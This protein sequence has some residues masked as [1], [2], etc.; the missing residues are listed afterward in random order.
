M[1]KNFTLVLLGLFLILGGVNA[2]NYRK[3]DFT[4]WSA[5]TIANLQADAAASST[6]GWSDIE[7]AADAGDG[8]VA[9]DATRNNC[10]WY[11]SSE[12]GTLKANGVTISELEGLDFGSSY[13]DNR[14]LAIA[15]NYPETSL[16]T[17]AGPAYLW[18][19]GGNK[20]AGS[21]L[22]CFTIP[23]VQIGQK[24]TMVVESHKPSDARGISLFVNDINVETN[25]I[26]ES[27]TPTTQETYTWEN[28]TLPDGVEDEDGDGLVDILVYNTNGCHIYSL[29]VGDSDQKSKIAYLYQGAPDATQAVAE[30]IANYEVE[31]IDITATQKTAEELKGYDAVIIASNVNDATYAAELKNA[32][33]W[34]PIVNTS[35]GLYEL[36]GLGSAVQ[37]SIPFVSIKSEGHS[38]FNGIEIIEEGEI[39]GIA[40][41]G[42]VFGIQNLGDYFAN[43]VIVGAAMDDETLTTIHV[44]NATHNAYIYIPAGNA[45][46][47]AN[48]IKA[49]ANSKGKVTAAPKPVISL[50]YKN[51]NTDVTITSGVPGAQIFYTTDGSEP[52][53]NST[54]YTETF[55]VTTACTVKAVAKGDGYTLSDVAES[56][57]IIKQQAAAPTIT[58]E[59]GNGQTTVTISGEGLIWYSY[60]N[61]NDTT[62][63][64]KYTEPIV[65][66]MPRTLYAFACADDKV[67][68]EVAVANVEVD[69]F[70]P[71]IDILAHMDANSAEYNG[72]S[73]SAGYYFSWGKD[74]AVYPYYVL[75]SRT[76]EEGGEDPETGDPIVN[77]VYTEMSPEEEKDF[78]N[79]WM[80]RSRGQLIVWEN[81][82]TGT[83]YG[84]TGGYNFATA[85]DENPYFP[86]TKS[87][88]NLADKNTQ[89]NDATFPYNAYITTTCKFK[90]P[91]DIVINAGSITKPES[92]GTHTLVLQVSTDGNVWES[93]WQT[94]GD[95]IV[96]TNIPRLTKNITRSYEG[97]DEVYVRA[98]LAG[99][100][101]KVGFYDIYI[102]NAGEKSAELKTGIVEQKAETTKQAAGI[103][104]L[105]GVRQQGMTRGLNII[106]EVDGTVKKVMVK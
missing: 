38:L 86:A 82:T 58:T 36:W 69:G 30:S 72:G 34:T 99:N 26:G 24:I 20:A 77:V 54:P 3:W 96:M 10:F 42:E 100:N 32:L 5:T 25:Q 76:E 17:Y 37:S 84:N 75:D 11:D 106:V 19:G 81:Q 39:K 12:G 103:Y 50:N 71:R 90:G 80:V 101:S 41:E 52:T 45:Q 91:F 53:E 68:S 18:L 2:Q 74:K 104:N 60:S 94:V 49:A 9:P 95:T 8:K 61:T 102:A 14:S 44:H 57:V 64:S 35:Y 78:E 43:D 87:Y 15:V 21:R 66:K 105:S 97:T 31:A 40:I 73:T 88:L 28:W 98:Y 48:A 79:G 47:T 51:N 67:N 83:S 23:N 46:L 7:K 65:V 55:N 13:S 6:T 56:A 16:G 1:K 63:A 4:Q 59:K 89:P 62:K 33:G 70:E 27:F 22:L 29:E 93:N 92:P 85:D